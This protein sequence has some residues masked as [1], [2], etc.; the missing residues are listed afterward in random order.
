MIQLQLDHSQQT[1]QAM[2][3]VPF[4]AHP[5]KMV[6]RWH[7]NTGMAGYAVRAS[8]AKY[9]TRSFYVTHH[10]GAVHDNTASPSYKWDILHA[11]AQGNKI[12]LATARAEVRSKWV[13]HY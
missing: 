11:F 9:I 3:H 8:V 10:A 7:G 5:A 12:D 1:W 13:D 6:L 4:D 2:D